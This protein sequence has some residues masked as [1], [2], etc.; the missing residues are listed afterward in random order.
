M[1]NEDAV[2]LEYNQMTQEAGATGRR[3]AR[4]WGV[5]VVEP[6]PVVRTGLQL[7]IDQEPDLEVLAAT[8]DADE[9]LRALARARRTRVTVLIALDLGGEQDSA[10]L[11]REVRERYP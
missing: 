2:R 6:L 9:A 8:G 5:I 4:R 1:V 7:L 10:W 3:G 11:I